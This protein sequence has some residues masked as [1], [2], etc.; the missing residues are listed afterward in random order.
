M[1][2]TPFYNKELNIGGTTLVKKLHK[3]KTPCREID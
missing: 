2:V 1:Y 3:I